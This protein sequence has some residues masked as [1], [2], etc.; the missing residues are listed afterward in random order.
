MEVFYT[1]GEICFLGQRDIKC[2]EF[3][4]RLRAR[5]FIMNQ[6]LLFY[7]VISRVA[8]MCGKIRKNLHLFKCI[9][10]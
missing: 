3:P 9:L 5:S 10:I 8:K 6:R 7:F 2:Q 4:T 1:R